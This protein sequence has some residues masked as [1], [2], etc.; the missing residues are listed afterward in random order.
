MLRNR[1]TDEL[2]FFHPSNNTMLLGTP[3]LIMNRRLLEDDIE[4]DKTLL[5]TPDNRDPRNSLVCREDHFVLD[6]MFTN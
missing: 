6:L 1:N 4:L 2:K 5:S 3:R